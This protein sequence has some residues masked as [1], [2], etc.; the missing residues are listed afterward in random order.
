MVGYVVVILN[1]TGIY[2]LNIEAPAMIIILSTL[3]F[4]PKVIHGS[5]LD[6][7][8]I[9]TA[10]IESIKYWVYCFYLIPLFIAAFVSLLVRKE[11]K[12]AKTHHLGESGPVLQPST[13]K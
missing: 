10:L 4:F 8:N 3:V 2:P 12:W 1:L 6:S 7:K 13:G 11:S 9:I 5:W